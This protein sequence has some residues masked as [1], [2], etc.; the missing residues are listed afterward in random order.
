MIIVSKQLKSDLANGKTIALDLGCGKSKKEGY[1][2]LDM[3]NVGEIDIIADLEKPL[4]ELP[5]C[6]VSS[7]FSYHCL[8]HICNLS[9]LMHELHRVLVPGGTLELY[10]P[11]FSNPYH[12]SDPTHVRSFGLYSMDYFSPICAK[13]VRGVPGYWPEIPFRVDSVWIQLF[14][15][16]WV[17]KLFFPGMS[18]IINSSRGWQDRYE[19]RLCRFFP[20]D[21]ICFKMTAIKGL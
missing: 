11:H 20:A 15:R 8:E 2:G 10:V 16:K 5:D 1:Y 21:T 17:D 3:A 19:R 13:G 14:E 6:S 7:V 12:Y 4:S 18:T 9:Q